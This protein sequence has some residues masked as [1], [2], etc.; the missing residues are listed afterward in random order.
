MAMSTCIKCGSSSFEMK[1]NEPRHSAWKYMFIQ[2]SSCG[3]VVGVV[4]YLNLGSVLQKIAKR[5][6]IPD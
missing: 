3:G 6:G 2:C 4:E 1:E 5:L